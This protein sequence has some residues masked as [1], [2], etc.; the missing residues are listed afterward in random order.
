[1]NTKEGTVGLHEHP[2]GSQ[3]LF[4]LQAI[5]G[6]KKTTGALPFESVG[7]INESRCPLLKRPANN[8]QTT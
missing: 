6:N 4:Q 3:G 1:M 8:P 5:W 2:K 7:S